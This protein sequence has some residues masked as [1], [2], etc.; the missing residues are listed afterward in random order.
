MSTY[1]VIDADGYRVGSLCYTAYEAE[2]L[3]KSI[4]EK[5]P[6]AQLSVVRFSGQMIRGESA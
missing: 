2:G 6:D 1:C 5:D 3:R 4:L